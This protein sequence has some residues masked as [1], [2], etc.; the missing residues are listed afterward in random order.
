MISRSGRCPWRTN[1]RRP[2]SV[3]LSA[4]QLSKLERIADRAFTGADDAQEA[5]LWRRAFGRFREVRQ[6]LWRVPALW[7]DAV[8]HGQAELASALG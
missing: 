2:T 8:L 4:W 1:R 7:H 5:S 6:Q 3:S